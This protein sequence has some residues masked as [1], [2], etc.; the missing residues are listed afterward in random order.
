MD[1]S[2]F[3]RS[4][5][6]P[7]RTTSKTPPSTSRIR[8]RTRGGVNGTTELSDLNMSL[9]MEKRNNS[10]ND[11]P[12]EDFHFAIENWEKTRK[13]RQSDGQTNAKKSNSAYTKGDPVSIAYS[14]QFKPIR[15]GSPKSSP[16]LKV[17]KTK[18]VAEIQAAYGIS[19]NSNNT[20]LNVGRKNSKE[21]KN[22]MTSTE[23]DNSGI[24]ASTPITSFIS[25][26]Q[27][28]QVRDKDRSP[29]IMQP[30][31]P[32]SNPPRVQSSQ[33][34]P[35]TS[36]QTKSSYRRRTDQVKTAP[37]N[38]VDWK[39][40][41][42]ISALERDRTKDSLVVNVS[43]TNCDFEDEDYAPFTLGISDSSSVISFRDTESNPRPQSRKLYLG[44]N[45]GSPRAPNIDIQTMEVVADAP[46]HT[47]TM[48]APRSAG[49]L[50]RHSLLSPEL[51]PSNSS[52]ELGN[53][54]SSN[55]MLS[56]PWHGNATNINERPPSRQR[57]AFPVHLADRENKRVRTARNSE[58]N[59][60]QGGNIPISSSSAAVARKGAFMDADET[61]DVN[62]PSS[63]GRLK[64][65]TN[66]NDLLL[67]SPSGRPPSRQKIAA[68][69]LWGDE[70]LFEQDVGYQI[71]NCPSDTSP[72]GLVSPVLTPSISTGGISLI[73]PE[74]Y[75][76]A[77]TSPSLP[78]S[79]SQSLNN[80]FERG[81][82][83]GALAPMYDPAADGFTQ[84]ESRSQSAP[85]KIRVG[86][87]HFGVI[88]SQFN[89]STK[90]PYSG[91]RN[92]RRKDSGSPLA[93]SKSATTIGSPGK[94]SVVPQSYV[95]DQTGKEQLSRSRSSENI[96]VI[97][98]LYLRH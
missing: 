57:T 61:V 65:A 5:T 63:T 15:S 86:F 78:L 8:P 44:G 70:A 46:T 7:T 55:I 17:S 72:D 14:S 38:A 66:A 53:H 30:H 33:Q 41:T 50:P 76:R 4:G 60:A 85:F 54:E 2:E 24:K 82:T 95:S 1:Y 27:R 23:V 20:E 75:S 91:N 25:E 98:S 19:Q 71:K 67:E 49:A 26:D 6:A 58:S 77:S 97:S 39:E 32:R 3:E 12:V 68:Q 43:P 29:E 56:S 88:L 18:T 40:S 73:D 34:N 83:R 93:T 87:S 80:N 37:S 11:D 94:P 21:I 42:S 59:L 9:K 31:P 13:F 92:L 69:Y 74:I 45:S 16:R 89:H 90:K 81:D 51:R 10:N 47:G 79:S 64:L 84:L 36:S 22:G 62:P 52:A 28:Y 48:K 35:V 96:D